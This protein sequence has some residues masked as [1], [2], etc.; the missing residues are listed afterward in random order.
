MPIRSLRNLLCEPSN[1]SKTNKNMFKYAKCWNFQYHNWLVSSH[2]FRHSILDNVDIRRLPHHLP[3]SSD[4]VDSF[5]ADDIQF[6]MLIFSLCTTCDMDM[7]FMYSRQV[8]ANLLLGLPLECCWVLLTHWQSCH[9]AKIHL[10]RVTWPRF[11]KYTT[12]SCQIDIRFDDKCS[13]TDGQ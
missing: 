3:P 6:H 8:V 2:S 7:T 10:T 5:N 9:M 12:E 11:F 4:K 1:N 13:T